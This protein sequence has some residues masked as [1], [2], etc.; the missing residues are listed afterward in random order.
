[1]KTTGIVRRMDDLGRLAIP[2]EL[3]TMMKLEDNAPLEIWTAR[4][5]G[6]DI[7][8]L[9]KY[10]SLD[11]EEKTPS[12]PTAPNSESNSAQLVEIHDGDMTHYVRLNEAAEQ[13]LWWLDNLGM[14]NIDSWATIDD[15]VINEFV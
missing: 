5:D 13:L 12:T 14:L 1:M 6:R 15:I 7:I 2:K 10:V 8:C 3:R 9:T 11:E 4:E